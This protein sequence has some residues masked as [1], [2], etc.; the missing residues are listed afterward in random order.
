MR[1]IYFLWKMESFQPAMLVYHSYFCRRLRWSQVVPHPWAAPV[2]LK[3]LVTGGA[4]V[5]MARFN[6]TFLWK[7]RGNLQLSRGPYPKIGD[8]CLFLFDFFCVC[9]HILALQRVDFAG[10]VSTWMFFKPSSFFRR[11]NRNSTPEL[12]VSF[13]FAKQD[14]VL[15]ES[16]EQRP[17]WKHW[18]EALF[19]LMR[20]LD[21][22]GNL[23]D[24]L[25]LIYLN[26]GLPTTLPKTNIPLKIGLPKRK[27]VFQQ[28]L[29]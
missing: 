15:I 10:R 5:H 1:S 14:L 16:H 7:N 11:V 19:F 29:C 25:Q 8:L 26:D 22:L 6:S 3:L 4:A 21:F 9:L 2:R 17:G 27:L 20:F 12:P 24:D 28:R 18:W 23:V 13:F